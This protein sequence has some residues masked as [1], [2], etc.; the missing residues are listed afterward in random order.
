MTFEE[1]ILKRRSIR[2]Y[3]DIP[4]PK[5]TIMRSFKTMP[6]L[7][8]PVMNSLGDLSLLPIGD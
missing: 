1:L 7:Q 4:V 8:V 3:Q 6:M 5:E 2:N